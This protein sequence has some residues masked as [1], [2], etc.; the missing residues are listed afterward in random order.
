MVNEFW[1]LCLRRLSVCECVSLSL[2]RESDDKYPHLCVGSFVAP[3]TLTPSHSPLL[4]PLAH[5][6]SPNDSP[7]HHHQ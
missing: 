3:Y 4:V 7:R 6:V 2:S 5:L 1:S